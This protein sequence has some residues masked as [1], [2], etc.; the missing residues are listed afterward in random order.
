MS[1][2]VGPSL[3]AAAAGGVRGAAW[4][5]GQWFRRAALP[6]QEAP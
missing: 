1:S 6:G 2:G 5:T 4:M 3:L